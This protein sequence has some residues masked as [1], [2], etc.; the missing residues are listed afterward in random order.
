MQC[1]WLRLVRKPNGF[2]IERERQPT[3]DTSSSD[4]VGILFGLQAEPLG[5]P[6]SCRQVDALQHLKAEE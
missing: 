4:R 6:R 5:L 1:W 2:P 3:P